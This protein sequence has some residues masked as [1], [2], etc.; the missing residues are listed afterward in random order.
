MLADGQVPPP[1]PPATPTHLQPGCPVLCP[2][3]GAASEDVSMDQEL[4]TAARFPRA[5]ISWRRCG[6]SPR[7]AR[8]RRS[9]LFRVCPPP[10]PAVGDG[11]R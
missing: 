2:L 10:P 1:P 8:Q 3:I 9:I 7:L 6:H 5:S 11:R 4:I